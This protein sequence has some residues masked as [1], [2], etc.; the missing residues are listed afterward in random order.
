MPIKYNK[1][2]RHGP[3]WPLFLIRHLHSNGGS[4]EQNKKMSKSHLLW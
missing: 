4:Y 1:L 2:V 3:M